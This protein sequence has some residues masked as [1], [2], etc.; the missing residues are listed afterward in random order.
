MNLLELIDHCRS[1]TGDRKKPYLWPNDEFRD[2]LN[3]AGDDACIRAR[4]IENEEIELD[5]T[6]GDAYAEIPEHLW[7]ILRVTFDGRKLMLC[8]KVMLDEY[9]GVDWEART[10]DVPIACYEV[11]GRLRF[12]PI[13]T[14]AGIVKA[15]AFCTPE[16][17]LAKD[18]DVPEWLRTRLHVKLVDGALAIAYAKKDADTFDADAAAYH[19][20]EFEKI[21]GPRPDEKA[22][23]RLRINVRRYVKGAY[24]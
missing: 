23:R 22:I 19:D 1:V 7:S 14:T 13:P 24:F 17:P 11:G 15:H 2:A 9:E 3:E 21:F 20:A 10:A 16:N 18:E 12:Y 6:A 4:L 5:H 8:D